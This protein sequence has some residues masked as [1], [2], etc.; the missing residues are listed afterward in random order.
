MDQAQSFIDNERDKPRM[1]TVVKLRV[2]NRN[3]KLLTLP[4]G[5]VVPP[6]EHE[7]TV[8]SDHVNAVL[9]MVETDTAAIA[10]AEDAYWMRVAKDVKERISS[11]ETAAQILARIRA[12]DADVMPEVNAVRE[13]APYSPQSMFWDANGRDLLP[14]V[15]AEVIEGSEAIEPQRAR[16]L[17]QTKLATEAMR[18]AFAPM[19]A[20]FIEQEVKRRVDDALKAKQSKS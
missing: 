14:L 2:H 20:G 16:E 6:G 7:I 17:H 9:G 18:D 10:R 11:G 8:Y 5:N 3:T 19:F 13:V 1:R 12:N 15:S 4:D